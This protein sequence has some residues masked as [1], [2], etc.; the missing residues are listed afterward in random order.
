MHDEF[1]VPAAAKEAVAFALLGYDGIHGR[2][3]NI[4]GCTG[5]RRAVTLGK[6]VPGKNYQALLS[7]VVAEMAAE[8][9]QQETSSASP[10]RLVRLKQ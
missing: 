7:R 4:P 1:G 6:L 5:A 2:S 9:Q 3:T 8:W 10:D